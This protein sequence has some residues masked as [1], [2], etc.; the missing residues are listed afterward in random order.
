MSNMSNLMTAL[1]EDIA[2]GV[3]SFY[4]IADKHGVPTSWVNEAW[5]ALC[6][7]ELLEDQHF[8][9]GFDNHKDYA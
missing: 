9:D 6:E 1:Q 4:Q 7:Q 2:L 8:N 5:E 3:L